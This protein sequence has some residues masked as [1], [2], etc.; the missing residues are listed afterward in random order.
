MRVQCVGTFA[1]AKTAFRLTV[2]RYEIE[3][4]KTKSFLSSDEE[5]VNFVENFEEN[6]EKLEKKI[7]ILQVDDNNKILDEN[8]FL[9]N[10]YFADST[11]TN[12]PFI[13]QKVKLFINSCEFIESDTKPNNNRNKK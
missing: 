5:N 13:L 4:K 3:I 2:L 6:M 11:L 8:D 7:K 12:F 10:N 9:Y 1:E